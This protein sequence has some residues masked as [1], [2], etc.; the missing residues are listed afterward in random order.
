MMNLT[1]ANLKT[2]LV[3]DGDS[4]LSHSSS[5]SLSNLAPFL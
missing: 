4:D 1:L 3:K 2:T 5:H